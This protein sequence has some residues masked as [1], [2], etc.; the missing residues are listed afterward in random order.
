MPLSIVRL[1][2]ATLMMS[3]TPPGLADKLSG[4]VVRVL[5]G[6]SL[7]VE[8]VYDPG[9]A[10]Y[11]YED[12]DSEGVTV[13]VGPHPQY[14]FVR[15]GLAEVA[16][17]PADSDAGALAASALADKVLGK[18]VSVVYSD[19]DHSGRFRSQVFVEEKWINE[20]M[21]REG[22]AVHNPAFG[23]DPDLAAAETAAKAARLGIWKTR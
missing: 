10:A 8:T 14:T 5:N 17:P 4:S 23:N 6:D 18:K 2:I 20:E 3:L 19:I 11:S 15:I 9:Y 7:L 22:L 1:S 16:A 13:N 12:F 21:I